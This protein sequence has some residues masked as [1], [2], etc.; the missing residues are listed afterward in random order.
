MHS[1]RHL[2]VAFAVPAP[3][4]SFGYRRC[5]KPRALTPQYR[6]EAAMP[7]RVR[8]HIVRRL[9]VHLFLLFL[10]L[11]APACTLIFLALSAPGQI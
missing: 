9:I 4:L 11:S 6:E 5:L 2:Q 8:E 3:R 1:R 7:Q 10:A